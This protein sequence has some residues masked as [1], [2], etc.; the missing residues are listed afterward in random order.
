VGCPKSTYMH[1]LHW[2]GEKKELV[3]PSLFKRGEN[4]PLTNYT[5]LCYTIFVANKEEL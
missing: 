2:E 4:Y 5:I 1:L 3:L